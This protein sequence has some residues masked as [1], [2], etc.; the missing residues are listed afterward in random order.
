MMA[1]SLNH[2]QHISY[3]KSILAYIDAIAEFGARENNFRPERGNVK[4]LPLLFDPIGKIDRRVGKI[5]LYC[6]RISDRVLIIGRGLVTTASRNS[7][8]PKIGEIIEEL[9]DI[10]H[11]IW[12]SS[13]KRRVEYEDYAG[14]IDII[15]NLAI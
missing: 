14:I 4:A 7:E 11:A 2:P 9:R 13:Q 5:R 6:I 1:Q 15:E 10:E 12:R 3:L 8:D